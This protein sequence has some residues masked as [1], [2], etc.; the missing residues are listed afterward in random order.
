MVAEHTWGV[1]IKT[2]LRDDTAWDRPDFEARAGQRLPLRL[3]GSNPGPSSAAIVDA[4]LAE[5]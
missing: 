3:H 2:Y 1:D 4:A 5:P